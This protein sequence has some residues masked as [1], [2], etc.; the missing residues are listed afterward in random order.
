MPQVKPRST[1]RT[2]GYMTPTESDYQCPHFQQRFIGWG[3]MN[4]KRAICE[5]DD[6]N[7]TCDYRYMTRDGTPLCLRYWYGPKYEITDEIEMVYVQKQDAN[8]N[9][10]Y[11]A[12]D[13]SETTDVTDRR[14]MIPLSEE[15]P[16]PYIQNTMAENPDTGEMEPTHPEFFSTQ[17]EDTHEKI[18]DINDDIGW[19]KKV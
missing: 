11:R 12:A 6:A 16:V 17:Y 15:R 10:L 8:G 19:H 18:Y 2:K 7:T 13:D 4:E 14:V 1:D 9:L 3:E 5:K